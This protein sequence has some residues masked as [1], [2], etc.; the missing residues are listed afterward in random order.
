MR[1]MPTGPSNT[2]RT[3]TLA[4]LTITLIAEEPPMI[5]LERNTSRCDVMAVARPMRSVS[6]TAF[7]LLRDSNQSIG[8]VDFLE[9][10]RIGTIELLTG[11]HAPTDM[12]AGL[13]FFQPMKM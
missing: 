2:A 6:L 13:F 12:P 5:A 7:S 4:M 9:H 8:H 1:P 3:L 11:Q 10:P